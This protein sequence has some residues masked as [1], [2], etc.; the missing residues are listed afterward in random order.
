MP[1]V[2]E[3]GLTIRL[4]E[5]RTGDEGEAA[6]QQMHLSFLK[7]AL[8]LS[9]H[10]KVGPQPVWLWDHEFSLSLAQGYWVQPYFLCQDHMQIRL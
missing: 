9:L 8:K 10:W 2:S 5:R 7:S 6:D 1:G 3:V 4:L